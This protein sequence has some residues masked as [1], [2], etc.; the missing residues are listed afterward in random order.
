MGRSIVPTSRP[1]TAGDGCTAEEARVVG[2]IGERPIPVQAASK[3]G[4]ERVG[5]YTADSTCTRAA[6]GRD[7]T[8]GVSAVISSM[9][10][11][12]AI[13]SFEKLPSE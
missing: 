8:I 4:H 13:G 3:R 5:C 2:P 1:P 11:M 10:V 7:A 6:A 12:P 9:G